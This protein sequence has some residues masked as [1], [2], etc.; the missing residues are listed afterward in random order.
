MSHMEWASRVG[1]HELHQNAFLLSSGAT[2]EAIPGFSDHGDQFV[3]R[4]MGQKDIDKTRSS[5][6][7]SVDQCVLWQTGEQQTGQ[8]A[9]FHSRGLSQYHRNV[10]SKIAVISLSGSFDVN[11]GWNIYRDHAFLDQS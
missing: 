5:H 6:L 10:A 9:W 4:I 7:R 11:V 2:T 3:E 8:I 1:G